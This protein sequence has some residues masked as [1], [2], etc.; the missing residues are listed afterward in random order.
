MYDDVERVL[1]FRV[2]TPHNPQEQFKVEW[3]CDDNREWTTEAI[4]LQWVHP[5]ERERV[6]GMLDAFKA[7]RLKNYRK[8]R[9]RRR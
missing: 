2:V 8:K 7:P 4:I 6:R 5:D 3:V 1:D 9:R